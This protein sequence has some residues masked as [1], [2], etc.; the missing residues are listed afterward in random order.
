MTI[1]EG[2]MAFFLFVVLILGCSPRERIIAEMEA[3]GVSA[4]VE[5][6][7]GRKL[8]NAMWKD[9]DLWIL[10]RPAGEGERADQSWMLDEYSGWGIFNK[11]IMLKEIPR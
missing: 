9:R 7:R 8:V 3:W 5:A 10:T 1:I 2:K 4:V 11:H 6:P